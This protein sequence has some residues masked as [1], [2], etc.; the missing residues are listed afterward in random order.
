MLFYIIAIRECVCNI[1]HLLQ[2]YKYLQSKTAAKVVK[3][4]QLCKYHEKNMY[5]IGLLRCCML[6]GPCEEQVQLLP[7]PPC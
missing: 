4:N 7:N 1:N 6:S 5:F 3:K 2:G